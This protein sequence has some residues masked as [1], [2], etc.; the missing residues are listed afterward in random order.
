MEHQKQY[1]NGREEVKHK[2]KY[3]DGKEN[4]NKKDARIFAN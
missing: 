2:R 3:G 1:L 4:Q